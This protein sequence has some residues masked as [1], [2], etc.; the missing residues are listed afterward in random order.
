MREIEKDY[1]CKE[2]LAQ[3]PGFRLKRNWKAALLTRGM[4][5]LCKV[6][7]AKDLKLYKVSSNQLSG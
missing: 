7:L 5:H 2:R 3:T 4:I 1:T 6:S